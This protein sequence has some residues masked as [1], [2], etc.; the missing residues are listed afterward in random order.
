MEKLFSSLTEVERTVKVSNAIIA[1]VFNQVSA[2]QQLFQQTGGCHAASAATADG[3]LI[4]LYEDIGRHNAVDKVIGHLLENNQLQQAAILTVSG[5]ISFEIIQK[6]SRAGIPV[7]AAISAP[8]S[9]AV[10][11]AKKSNITLAAFCRNGKATF[12]SGFQRMALS[13]ENLSHKV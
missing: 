5:R 11:M 2:K 9:L 6:C 1:S 4:C 7:L 10:D 8:S 3:Q 13:S 12:Y